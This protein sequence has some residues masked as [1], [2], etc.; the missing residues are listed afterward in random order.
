MLLFIKN[1]FYTFL[2]II[3]II[4]YP[5]LYINIILFYFLLIKLK[6]FN[7]NIF[8]PIIIYKLNINI[9]EKASRKN[10]IYIN[11]LLFIINQLSNNK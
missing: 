5:T 10:S 2:N 9:L 3:K 1:K 4:M 8:Q 6:L 7:N 11:N